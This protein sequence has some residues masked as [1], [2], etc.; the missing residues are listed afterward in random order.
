MFGVW[1]F[2]TGT[3]NSAKPLYSDP[4]VPQPFRFFPWVTRAARMLLFFAHNH[5]WPPR[6]F[7]G[8]TAR[9]V[10]TPAGAHRLSRC[11]ATFVFVWRQ[12][13]TMSP[14]AGLEFLRQPQLVLHSNLL[15]LSLKH[16]KY[17]Y[18]HDSQ[19]IL[20]ASF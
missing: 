19:Q 1:T 2:L 11:L 9:P 20:Y 12:C 17:R 6:F 14:Q 15:P 3:W 4:A 5:G 13:L 8:L 18:T 16:W 7:T 10:C